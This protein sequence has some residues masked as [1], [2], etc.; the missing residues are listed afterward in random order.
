MTIFAEHTE[1]LENLRQAGVDTTELLSEQWQI[2][3]DNVKESYKDEPEVY[4]AV[5]NMKKDADTEYLEWKK[6]KWMEENE[7][8]V[9]GF[10]AMGDAYLSML[11]DMLA[12]ENMQKMKLSKYWKQMANSFILEVNRMMLKW[13]AFQALKLII[14]GGGALA[15]ILKTN[16]G[17]EV[18]GA[19]LGGQ[20]IDYN[21]IVQMSGGGEMQHG[22]DLNKDS[23]LTYLTKNEIVVNRESSQ[24]KDN[25]DH[26][27]NINRDKEYIYKNFIPKDILALSTGGIAD[28]KNNINIPDFNIPDIG[29]ISF[30]TDFSSSQ[31][32]NKLDVLIK[33][34]YAL[35]M[36][37]QSRSG[38]TNINI[39]SQLDMESFIINFDKTRSDMVDRG[40]Q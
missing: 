23:I 26:L 25:R 34:I 14:P 11:D 31:L 3:A 28:I 4:Q 16:K 40:Y 24:Y 12:G 20:I 33:S 10:N 29:N 21:K 1:Q 8:A 32:S 37:Q 35:N 18:P 6:Q 38:Q 7:L 15:G 9:S 27:L 36:N 22:S 2:F 17:G 5:L 19:N 13:L 30:P 39:E